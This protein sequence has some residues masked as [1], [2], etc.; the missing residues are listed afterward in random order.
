[1]NDLTRFN[2][3]R[4]LSRFDPF[5]REFDE[6][7]KGFF[8]TPVPF[9]QASSGTIPIDVSE[10]EQSFKIR[11]EIPGFAKED[12]HISVNGDQV[13]I[14]AETRKENE[15]KKDDRVVFRECYY[16]KQYRSFTLAQ[17]VDDA[18][19]TAKYEDGV[20][21]IVLPKKASAETRKITVN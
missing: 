17:P 1:M 10:D 2:P 7:F 5:G 6:L 14:S 21:N 12:I 15:E 3:L 11:A 16:G 18:A 9:A 13:A 8:L 4:G 20:L 19:A